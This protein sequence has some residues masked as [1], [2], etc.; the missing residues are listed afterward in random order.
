MIYKYIYIFFIKKNLFF[1][2]LSSKWWDWKGHSVKI[3]WKKRCKRVKTWKR[4]ENRWSYPDRTMYYSVLQVVCPYH[5]TPQFL[6]RVYHHFD[7]YSPSVHDNR[8]GILIGQDPVIALQRLLKLRKCL[9]G[10]VSAIA[11][12]RAGFTVKP[13]DG[14]RNEE[15][16]GQ[17]TES[18]Q[19]E[20]SEYSL[21]A[22][23]VGKG[24]H[25]RWLSCTECPQFGQ[26][27]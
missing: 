6:T 1:W 18:D 9:G 4:Q 8:P 22:Y 12:R 19:S 25:G 17:R 13:P 14:I 16:R 27:H 11:W 26:R 2:L 3:K 20:C 7:V 10:H 21:V 23:L 15:E 24:W 5:P